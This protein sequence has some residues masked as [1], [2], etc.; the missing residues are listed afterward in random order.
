MAP[1]PA[2]DRLLSILRLTQGSGP[3]E[4][5]ALWDT[6]LHVH[7]SVLLS[8]LLREALQDLFEVLLGLSGLSG[9]SAGLLRLPE[10]L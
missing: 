9:P 7:M 5:K 10:A 6:F 3:E 8:V 4:D 2:P 1:D